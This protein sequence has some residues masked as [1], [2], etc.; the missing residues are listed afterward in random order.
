[1]S[2]L[3]DLTPAALASHGLERLV[4]LQRGQVMTIPQFIHYHLQ[5]GKIVRALCAVFEPPRT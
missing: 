2:A 5:A 4:A 1:M 3:D